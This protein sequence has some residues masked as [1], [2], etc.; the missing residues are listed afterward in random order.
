MDFGGRT[1]DKVISLF[2][3]LISFNEMVLST[4][5]DMPGDPTSSNSNYI[6]TFKLKLR[7]YSE[8]ESVKEVPVCL[9]VGLSLK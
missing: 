1:T 4:K 6:G 5:M 3:I 7:L 9:L 8:C 2:L